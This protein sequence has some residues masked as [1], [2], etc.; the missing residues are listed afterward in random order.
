MRDVRDGRFARIEVVTV[1]GG[2][3]VRVTARDGMVVMPEIDADGRCATVRLRREVGPREGRR[4]KVAGRL[5]EVARRR[6][7]EAGRLW[8]QDADTKAW[9]PWR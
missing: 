2:A 8:L 3:D 1:D 5:I 7:D 6:F 4:V 9:L